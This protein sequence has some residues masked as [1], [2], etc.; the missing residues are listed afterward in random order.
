MSS[1]R[2]WTAVKALATLGMVGVVLW[3]VPLREVG[4]RLAQLGPMDIALLVLVTV[5]QVGTGVVRW[6]RL[7]R[8]LGERVPF[9]SLFGD[10]LVGLLYNMFLP[11]AVGGDVVRAWRASKR[12]TRAHCA[13]STSLY[14]RLAGLVAMALSGAL[15]ATVAVGTLVKVP[16]SVRGLS[17]GLAV[18]LVVL[19]F[20]ASTP[21]RGLVRLLERRIPAAAVGE[22]A[23]IVEDLEGGLATAGAR[24]EAL[25][26][27][28]L[29]QALGVVFVLVGARALGAP[30]HTVAIVVGVPLVHI[31]SM[32]PVTLGGHGLREGL[33]VGVLGELGVA[34]EVA[35]GL[36]A[37]WLMSS[38]GFALAGGA[39]VLLRREGT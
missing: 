12:V 20:A 37:Q 30:G 14:E 32:I 35:L 24:T 38:L 8:R 27:S 39:V 36:A 31:L 26:W 2:F 11:T 19:F 34:P 6:W 17:L 23:G 29:Y 10:T 15:A 21:F 16:S 18:A 25:G 3:K 33:F 7:L 13:W 1:K 5:A 9:T 28:L 22:L 4:S